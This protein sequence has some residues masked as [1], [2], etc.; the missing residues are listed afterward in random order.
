MILTRFLICF[1]DRNLVLWFVITIFFNT[2]PDLSLQSTLVHNNASVWIWFHNWQQYKWAE[3]YI[4]P[5]NQ[6]QYKNA[7]LCIYLVC[8]FYM[9][10]SVDGEHSSWYRASPRR[11]GFHANSG[12]IA[13]YR[14]IWSCSWNIRRSFFAFVRLFLTTVFPDVGRHLGLRSSLII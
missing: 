10:V 11:K 1:L 12:I 3:L 6:Q 7:L 5:R 13:S 9:K 14:F 2:L 8:S 4:C